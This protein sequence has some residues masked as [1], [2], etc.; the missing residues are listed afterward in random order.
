M[1]ILPAYIC[2]VM[3]GDNFAQQISDI[4]L[5]NDTIS[6]RISDMAS[7]IQ[8]QYYALQLDETTDVAGLAQLLTY[9]GS[10]CVANFNL[11]CNIQNGN[12]FLYLN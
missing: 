10:I 8:S 4:P 12:V 9:Y 5:A 7:D 6:R 2:Q 1:L 11:Q 3:F